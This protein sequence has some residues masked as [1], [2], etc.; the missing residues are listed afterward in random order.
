MKYIKKK[1]SIKSRILRS[2]LT[3]LIIIFLGIVFSFNLLVNTYIQKSSNT[4]LKKATNLVENFDKSLIPLKYPKEKPLPREF[5]IHEREENEFPEFMKGVQ[6]K[7][8]MAEMQSNAEAMVIDK[9]YNLVFP[10]RE[11]DFLKD[12]NEYEFILKQIKNDKISLEYN[13]PFKVS[14][15]NKKYYASILKIKSVESI[16][17]NYLVLFIDISATLN[18]ANQINTLLILVMIIAGILATLTAIVLSNK[19]A[20]PI[21]KLCGFA[22]N[23]GKGKFDKNDFNFADKELDELS[24]IMNKS[25]EYLDK[26]DKEQKIFF[27]NASHELRTPLMSIKGYAEAIKYNVIDKDSASHVILEESNR[28]SDMVEELLYIS[29]IDNI[30]KDYELV[31]CDIRELLSNCTLKQKARAL[32]KGIEFKYDFDEEEVL[33]NC[34]EK[35]MYRAFLNIIENALRYAKSQIIIGCK[36]TNESIVVYIEDDGEGIKNEDL[37]YIFDRFYKGNKGKHG[38]GLSIVKSIIKKHDGDIKAE[39]TDLGAKF[40]IIIKS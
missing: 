21:Q 14:T 27:Q 36:K 39:N 34:D 5:E 31:E 2:I 40:T 24:K 18:L 17:D 6:E 20:R 38:I 32:N 1:I 33:L 12:I 8:R 11:E 26:Y 4:E 10:T 3:L 35:S 25:A 37:D 23:I 28:L 13:E 15:K 16:E 22:K 19:I 7:V 30:T 9:N 29:K